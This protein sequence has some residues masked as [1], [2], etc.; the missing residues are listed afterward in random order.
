M[1]TM[2]VN[3]KINGEPVSATVPTK[4]FLLDYLDEK[5][6]STGI[7]ER[8]S[9]LK[10]LR[11]DLRLT[12]SKNGCGTNHCGNCMVL[13]NGVPKKSCLL[14][15]KTLQNAEVTTIEGLTSNG[16]LHPIQAA[17]IN[18]GGSQCG[19]CTPGMVIATK[20]LL[21]KNPNPSE[22]EIKKGLEDVICRCT[23]YNKIIDAVRLA[24]RSLAQSNEAELIEAGG[25]GTSV[26]DFDGIQKAKGT[27]PYADD[28]FM[29]GMLL[30]KAVWSKYPHAVITS[31]D[32]AAAEAVPGV[33]R[34]LTYKDVPGLN[35]FG[36]IKRDQPL[37][38]AVGEKV[39]FIGDAI[40]LVVAENDLA[41]GLQHFDVVGLRQAARR[42]LDGVD[43]LVVAR[44]AADDV[45]KPLFDFGL[46]RVGVL[47]QQRLGGNNHA[48]C[49]EAALAAAGVD[50]G[51]LDGV[52]VA[53]I[54]HAFD[55]RDLGVLEALHL[56]QARLLGN[57]VDQHQA[58][59]AVVGAAAVLAARQPQVIA[60]ILQQAQPLGD[61]RAE[62]LLV[63][64]VEQKLFGWHLGADRL[65]V[66][67]EVD[68]KRVHAR[69]S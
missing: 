5:R 66:D 30:L 22:A 68:R 39:R 67:F 7:T 60:Q 40:A 16:D 51:R 25:L 1:D 3:F 35:R 43:N 37:L 54:G 31:L 50:E 34:V 14:Q 49:A 9:L 2:T 26:I 15:M 21:A 57:A 47:G 45:F 13:V 65:A 4:D 23:G 28:L 27:L 6:L 38:A 59:A 63:Q 55:G 11:D 18:S 41:A 12:G 42:H 10:F 64:V 62:P 48:G 19:F 29:D 56:Q 58:V 44:A 20:A 8:L 32:T 33:V 61:G 36:V 17:F 52:Q 53:V 69:T 24:A 46:R